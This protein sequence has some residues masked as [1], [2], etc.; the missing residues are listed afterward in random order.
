MHV[1]EQPPRVHTAVT[2]LRAMILDSDL[3]VRATNRFLPLVLA[4]AHAMNA[5]LA[6]IDPGKNTRS[7]TSEHAPRRL[8]RLLCGM[9]PLRVGP[10]TPML[11]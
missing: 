5:K 4:D 8:L 2:A 1:L 9:R 3:C 6:S 7:V 10:S 11:V